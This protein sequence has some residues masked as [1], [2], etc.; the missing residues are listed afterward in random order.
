M[1]FL[2]AQLIAVRPGYC[3]IHLPYKEELGQH[4]GFFHAGA[5]GTVADNAAGYAAY[6]LMDADSGIL[7]VEF[8]LSL[9]S[10]GD[11]E[12]LVARG[13]VIKAGRQLSVCQSD[14]YAVRNGKEKQCAVALVTLIQLAAQPG[15]PPLSQADGSSAPPHG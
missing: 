15:R 6:S 2:G 7:T 9:L 12:K 10:P 14:V 13:H 4:H 5:I 3:E 1:D 11:G 8:K